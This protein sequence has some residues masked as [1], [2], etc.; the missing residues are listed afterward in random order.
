LAQRVVKNNTD[1]TT[2]T[3]VRQENKKCIG[4]CYKVSSEA[5]DT[6]E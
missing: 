6:M 2:E 3:N 5:I 4:L 1:A